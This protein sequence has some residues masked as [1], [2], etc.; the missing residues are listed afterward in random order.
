MDQFHGV[1]RFEHVLLSSP[2]SMNTMWSVDACREHSILEQDQ[3]GLQRRRMIGGR[4]SYN[5]LPC[6]FTTHYVKLLYQLRP[7]A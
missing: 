4:V 5:A 6:R 7:V 2:A 3:A 1:Y